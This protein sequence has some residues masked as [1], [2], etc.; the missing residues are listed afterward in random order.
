MCHRGHVG[1]SEGT[2]PEREDQSIVER[3]LGS[4]TAPQ[5][6]LLAAGAL[7]AAILAIVALVQPVLGVFGSSIDYS[8]DETRTIRS[9]EGTAD[10]FIELLTERDGEQLMLDHQ[11]FG[12]LPGHNDVR[13][14]YDCTDSCSVL[15]IALPD[16]TPNVVKNSALW[17]QGCYTVQMHGSGYGSEPLDIGLLYRGET[18]G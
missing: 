18:C 5:R 10:R 14:S 12:D 4:R 6:L 9:G 13:V 11:V 17:F 2:P 8:P 7:A 16:S 1:D 3:I 15:R